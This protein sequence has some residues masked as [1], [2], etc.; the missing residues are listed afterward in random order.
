MKKFTGGRALAYPAPSHM[1]PGH[2][3]IRCRPVALMNNAMWLRVGM[4]EGSKQQRSTNNLQNQGHTVKMPIQIRVHIISL[5]PGVPMRTNMD[6][7][8]LEGNIVVPVA[9][10]PM[11]TTM[12]M[13][14]TT[15]YIPTDIPF[16]IRGI[17]YST[18]YW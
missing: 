4:L 1:R 2:V 17:P 11:T 8:N 15:S 12:G 6:M 10:I 14:T 7:I 16:G 18:I 13:E 3:Y 9:V 5:H